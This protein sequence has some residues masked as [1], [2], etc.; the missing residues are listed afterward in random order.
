MKY[1]VILVIISII[2]FVYF[3]NSKY[4]IENDFDSDYDFIKYRLG[5]QKKIDKLE[6][7]ETKNIERIEEKEDE[8][9]QNERGWCYMGTDRG[10]RSCIEVGVN[11]VC[12]SGSI[13]PNKDIC[14]NPNIR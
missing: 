6:R 5:L 8:T 14:I 7:N 1:I 10:Y 13:F 3:R 12:M 9:K 11:D 2:I 4:F